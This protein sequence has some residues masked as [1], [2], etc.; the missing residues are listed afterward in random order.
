MGTDL[1]FESA[2]VIGFGRSSFESPPNIG[3]CHGRVEGQI[4][5]SA[6]TNLTI[7]NIHRMK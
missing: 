5:V 7:H 1:F 3:L 6:H 4:P 2:V